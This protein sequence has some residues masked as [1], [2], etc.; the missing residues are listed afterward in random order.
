MHLGKLIKAVISQQLYLTQS[1]ALKV[2]ALEGPLLL[3]SCLTLR[4]GINNY[5]LQ[6]FYGSRCQ[7]MFVSIPAVHTQIKSLRYGID[8]QN[9]C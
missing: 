6:G 5:P 1:G 8:L 4:F 9:C 2:W 7:F 3:L